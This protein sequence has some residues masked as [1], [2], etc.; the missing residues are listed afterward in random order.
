MN[1]SSWEV[2]RSECSSTCGA[3]E[4]ILNHRCVQRR[5]ENNQ[6]MI[7]DDSYCQPTAKP[8]VY[9]SCNGPC[10]NARWAYDEWGQVGID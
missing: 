10:T 6:T 3:G 8:V 7:I 4:R 2:T 9:E 5:V 1:H